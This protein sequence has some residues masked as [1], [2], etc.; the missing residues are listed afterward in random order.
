MIFNL[1]W[2]TTLEFHPVDTPFVLPEKSINLVLNSNV[3]DDLLRKVIYTMVGTASV[4]S[5]K[6][7]ELAED[8]IQN[9]QYTEDEGRRIM[10]EI[11][12]Q[13]EDAY[14]ELQD[15]MRSRVDQVVQ[16]IQAPV[17]QQ[18]EIWM[19]E[20]RQKIKELPVAEYFIK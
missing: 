8:L 20:I 10:V 9:R 16:N 12:G 6:F 3:M 2:I 4:S 14:R 18:M 5:A 15:N 13:L 7:R 1:L 19:A 11:T 17:Q